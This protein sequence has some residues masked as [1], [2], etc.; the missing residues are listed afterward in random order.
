M[1]IFL[2]VISII[3]GVIDIAMFSRAYIKKDIPEMILW[4]VALLI[5]LN[6]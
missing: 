4:G 2:I 3:L 5:L 1:T 6:K